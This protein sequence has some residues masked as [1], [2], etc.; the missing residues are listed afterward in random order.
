MRTGDAL[1]ECYLNEAIDHSIFTNNIIVE[2]NSE[3]KIRS[4]FYDFL[5]GKDIKISSRLLSDSIKLDISGCTDILN[6]CSRYFISVF[7]RYRLENAGIKSF[8]WSTCQDEAVCKSCR[9][10]NGKVFSLSDESIKL[11]G[12]KEGCRCI[13]L[14]IFD[15]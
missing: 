1:E 4:I 6:N 7:T 2:R 3:K 13:M 11:P 8:E 5:L 10:N 15:E 9:K 12:Q 14:P